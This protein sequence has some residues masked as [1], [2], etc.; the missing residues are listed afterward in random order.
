[1]EN[2]KEKLLTNIL[3][4]HASKPL[5]VPT[6]ED[7]TAQAVQEALNQ[8]GFGSYAPAVAKLMSILTGVEI[9]MGTSWKF[10]LF[11][12]VV[13]LKSTGGHNYITG[14]PCMIVRAPDVALR[15]DGTM[16][17]H[18]PTEHAVSHE[19]MRYATEEEIKAFLDNPSVLEWLEANTL[20]TA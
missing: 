7:P 18:L 6:H 9:S 17:N 19:T 13:P 14:Q 4:R 15:A 3:A 10:P 20:I 5:G 1:M 16:G 12:V 11:S 8:G 2:M